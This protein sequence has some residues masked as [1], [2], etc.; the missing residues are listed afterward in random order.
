MIRLDTT[1]EIDTPERVVLRYRLAGPG[2]R[3][4]AYGV[5]L[6][7]RG[8]ILGALSLL[9]AMLAAVVP[10]GAGIGMGGLMLTLFFLEWGYGA[11][12]EWTMA[13]RTPGKWLLGIR[14]VREDGSAGRFSDFL[15]RNLVRTADFL[16]GF[17]AVGLL[18]MLFDSR[19]RRLGDL[20]GGTV[21]VVEDRERM[22]GVVRIEPPVSEEE[23]QAMPAQ[24]RLGTEE[25]RVLEVFLR[26]LPKLSRQR[27][28]ELAALYG[29]ALESRT[30]WRAETWTRTL[31]LAYA[32]STGKER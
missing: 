22:L 12:C 6:A 2:R 31:V 23:R 29:P 20:V 9:F 18:S 4:A 7:C 14:V 1:A 8:V 21:V 24:I 11:L 10:G 27:A 13:G 30:G 15:L 17:F 32:K 26:R 28:E 16:P 5:D 3:A 19:F 25:R